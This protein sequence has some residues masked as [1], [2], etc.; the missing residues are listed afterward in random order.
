MEHNGQSDRFWKAFSVVLLVVVVGLAA[1]M[2]FQGNKPKYVY[3]ENKPGAKSTLAALGT[4]M[5]VNHESIYWVADLADK[6]LPFVVNIQTSAKPSDKDDSNP[7]PSSAQEEMMRQMEEMLGPGSG[8]QFQFRQQNPRRQRKGEDGNVPLGEGS[9]F[10]IR[11]DGYVVTNSHVVDGADNFKV[12][13][14]DGKE[15]PAKL[16]G[17]DNFKDI[18]LLKIDSTD[19]FSPATLGDSA[20]TR[21]GEPVV[22]IGSPLG[23]QA[24]VTAGIISTNQRSLKD[25]GRANDIRM[26]QKYLQTDAAINRGNSGGPLLNAQGEVIGINQAIARWDNNPMLTEG[27]AVPVEGI[28]FAIPINDVKNTIQQIMEKGKVIYPGISAQISSV[29]DFLK[30]EPNV[31]LTV[32]SGVYVSNV[33][34]EGPAARAGVEAGDVILS[35]NGIEVKTAEGLITEIDKYNVGDRVKL[36]IAR[37]GGEKQED[38]SVVLGELDLTH[39]TPGE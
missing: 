8:Q 3:Y 19:K 39:I 29:D 36:R 24:S 17:T 10:I 12:H 2:Y 30:S 25:L 9:G 5:N 11:E 22:A 26:P 34:L 21:I 18:A 33:S 15:Y 37:Q 20:S 31:K 14:N 35:I 23:L 13:T 6:A 32:K 4:S 27:G 16:I 1:A 7:A 28:G 38:V